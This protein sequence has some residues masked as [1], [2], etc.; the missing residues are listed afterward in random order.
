M[1]VNINEVPSECTLIAWWDI[2]PTTGQDIWH[3]TE[4][5]PELFAGE[6]F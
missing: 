3:V 2:N 1:T 6:E 4:N 5:E